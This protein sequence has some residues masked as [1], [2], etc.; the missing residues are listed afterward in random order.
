MPSTQPIP[1][2]RGSVSSIET[3]GPG[4]FNRVRNTRPN[5]IKSYN[6]YSRKLG[7]EQA[8][9]MFPGVKNWITS[10]KLSGRSGNTSRSA[11]K[12]T[13]RNLKRK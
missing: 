5:W 4:Y 10:E 1:I 9:A 11:R 8:N 3:N 6:S 7:K 13:R 12:K 2:S